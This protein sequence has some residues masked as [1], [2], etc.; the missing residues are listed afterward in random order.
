[1]DYYLTDEALALMNSILPHLLELGKFKVFQVHTSHFIKNWIDETEENKK[2]LTNSYRDVTNYL[3]DAYFAKRMTYDGLETDILVLTRKGKYLA[4]YGNLDDYNVATREVLPNDEI[5]KRI[6]Y[7]IVDIT[8]YGDFYFELPIMPHQ[9]DLLQIVSINTV[10]GTK[11]SDKDILL[12]QHRTLIEQEKVLQYLVNQGF[13]INRY[14]I[15]IE[16]NVYRQLTENGRKLKELG[17]IQAYDNWQQQQNQKSIDAENER[18]ISTM[19]L[20]NEGKWHEILNPLQK[21]ANESAIETNR[22]VRITNDNVR[23]TNS[24]M[25]LMLAVTVI[26]T[27]VSAGTTVLNYNYDKSKDD[28]TTQIKQRDS[29]IQTIQLLYSSGKKENHHDT[30]YVTKHDTLYLKK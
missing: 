29:T 1:M 16:D 17:T 25:K 2:L 4:A 30:V 6:T 3:V 26:L 9:S 5:I 27:A 8:P 10:N 28:A 7:I 23:K 12:N 15:K 22:N 24:T 19:H 11:P 20:I 21:S 13:A 14:D 18:K